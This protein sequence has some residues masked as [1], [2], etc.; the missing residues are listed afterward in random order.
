[1]E[2]IWSDLRG[3]PEDV[4]SP[5]WHREVLNA[6]EQKR[7]ADTHAYDDWAVAK[8]RIRKQFNH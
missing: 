2:D 1:M 4:P 5:E 7:G 6:R 3:K 8:E